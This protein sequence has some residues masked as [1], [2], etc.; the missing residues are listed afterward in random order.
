MLVNLRPYQADLA[1]SIK[2]E[3]RAGR[4]AVL[5]VLPTGGG[6]T[7]V[8]SNITER[9]VARGNSVVLC[10]HRQELLMQASRHL[11]KLGVQHG[12]I[13]PGHSMTG[14]KVQVA[15]V[16]TLARRLDR[17][18]EPALVIFDECH[19]CNGLSSCQMNAITALCTG[20]R[21]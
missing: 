20:F 21:V 5:A 6:K 3:F 14:D 16:Q 1:D 12:L 11:S 18:R 4:R 13:A 17:V 19:H 7:V 9:T 2:N 15:S 10:V 8:F